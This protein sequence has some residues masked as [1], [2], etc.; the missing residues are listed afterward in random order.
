MIL[1]YKKTDTFFHRLDAKTKLLWLITVSVLSLLSNNFYYLLI[2]FVSVLSLGLILK[3]SFKKIFSFAKFFFILA[4]GVI[5]FQGF[6]Y[7]LGN[8]SLFYL[9][10]K[11]FTLEG[12]IFGL[13]IALR[14][15]ILAFTIPIFIISTNP[16]EI[17]DS[18]SGYLKENITFLLTIVFRFIPLTQKEL[19]KIIYAQQ[20]RGLKKNFKWYFAVLIPLFT[21]ALFRA[22]YLA[23]SAE[24]RGF[25]S[26][27]RKYTNKKLKP[28]D[29]GM[30]GGLAIFSL[31]LITFLLY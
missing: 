10:G 27:K 25:G 31:I 16:K 9:L 12:L 29:W 26:G 13:A 5:I 19:E 21:K 24:S 2:I 8:K 11:S 20:S 18:L 3:I 6:F 30:I 28:L 14:L 23:L 15:F 4:G 7:P 22:K 1:E 17:I